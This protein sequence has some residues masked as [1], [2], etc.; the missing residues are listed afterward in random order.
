MSKTYENECCDCAVPGYPCL[1]PSCSNRK[2]PHYFCDKCEDEFEPEALFINEDGEELCTEC[3][4]S[5][6]ETVA[7]KE[8]RYG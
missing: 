7:Q 5:N 2:V 6:Y 8:R 4:L 1:G 3:F